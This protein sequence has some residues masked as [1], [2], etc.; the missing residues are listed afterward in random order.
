MHGDEK[1]DRERD[2][3]G[4][5]APH[6]ASPRRR[7]L[8]STAKQAMMT[9]G[10]TLTMEL[11]FD[12]PVREVPSNSETAVQELIAGNVVTPEVVASLQYA[13][14]MGVKLILVKDKKPLAPAT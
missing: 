6:E 9:V 7:F 4:E 13:A 5:G 11:R 14:V 1:T 8:E 12:S 2:T 10:S 3:L